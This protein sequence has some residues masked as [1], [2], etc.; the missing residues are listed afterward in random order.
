LLR[1]Q[2]PQPQQQQQQQ[3]QRRQRRQ[4]QQQQ[5]IERWRSSNAQPLPQLGNQGQQQRQRQQHPAP[6][7]ERQGQRYLVVVEGVNDMRAVRRAAAGADVYVLGTSTLADN[8]RVLQ[9]SS[10]AAHAAAHKPHVAAR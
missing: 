8:P 7:Q 6:Q 10:T 9:A 2:Q 1:Q 4:Q 3:Q 5:Q